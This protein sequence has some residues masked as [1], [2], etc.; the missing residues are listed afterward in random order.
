MTILKKPIRR[1]IDRKC[2]RLLRSPLIVE[3]T[4]TGLLR[5]WEKRRRKRYEISLETL[6]LRT[7]WNEVQKRKE[8]K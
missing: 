2:L 4:E 7:I 8:K 3:I 1:V 5:M 6:Y